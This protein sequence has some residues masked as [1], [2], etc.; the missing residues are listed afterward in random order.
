MGGRLPAES[1]AAVAAGAPTNPVTV[2]GPVVVAAAAGA[3]T[4]PVARR[5]DRTLV[6][7]QQEG[8][9]AEAQAVDEA[10]PLAAQQCDEPM[11]EAEDEAA[12]AK[13]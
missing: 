5:Q 2:T 1:V 7:Q 4:G 8:P 6:E 11:A 12:E 13:A 9:V 10:H 3:P